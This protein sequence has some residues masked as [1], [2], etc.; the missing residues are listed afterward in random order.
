VG[1]EPNENLK[2][3]MRKKRTSFDDAEPLPEIRE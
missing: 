2:R 3:K 1:K